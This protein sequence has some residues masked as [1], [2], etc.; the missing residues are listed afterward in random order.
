MRNHENLELWNGGNISHGD[1]KG[2]PESV[3][4]CGYTA[5]IHR[6][7][8]YLHVLQVLHGKKDFLSGLLTLGLVPQLRD[9]LVRKIGF[10]YGGCI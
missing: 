10:I 8:Y 9:V 2:K 1:T 7:M 3:N 6:L 4:V 5:F